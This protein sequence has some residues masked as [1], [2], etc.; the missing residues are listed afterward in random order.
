MFHV[1]Q[2]WLDAIDRNYDAFMRQIANLLP[3]HEGRYALL[4]DGQL[5]AIHD[6]PGTAEQEGARRF[7]GQPYSIQPV[8]I[9]PVDMGYWSLAAH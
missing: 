1:E 3:D 7:P 2:Q 8:V 9:D 6:S 5:I 4:H